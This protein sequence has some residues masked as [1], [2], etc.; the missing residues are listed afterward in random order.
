MLERRGGKR[1]RRSAGTNRSTEAS[2]RTRVMQAGS[3]RDT[4]A[5]S[6]CIGGETQSAADSIEDKGHVG[7]A[8]GASRDWRGDGSGIESRASSAGLKVI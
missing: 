7:A 5:A 1:Q 3:Q 8:M 2:T 4:R 6:D